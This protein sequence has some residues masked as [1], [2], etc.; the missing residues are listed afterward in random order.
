MP[1]ITSLTLQKNKKRVNVFFDGKFAFGLKLETVTSLGL[2][3]GQVLTNAQVKKLFF[4]SFFEKLY[5]RVLN[6]LSYRPRSEKEVKDYLYKKFYQLKKLDS[7]FKEKLKE[8]ILKKLKKQELLDDLEFSTWWIGQRLDF[9]FFGKRR[10]R[11]ELMAKGIKEE[12]I[13]RVLGEISQEKL[14]K[15][16]K[17]LLQKK[18]KTYKKLDPQK[19][20]EKLIGHLQRR[21]FSWEIIKIAIDDFFAK[22]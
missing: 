10:L 7:S 18:K 20:K 19:L 11:G 13:D 12:I 3:K 22:D 21:G 17:R 8:K 16:A 9:K 1:Q 4:D 15:L 14:L 5:N 2:N 6:Y